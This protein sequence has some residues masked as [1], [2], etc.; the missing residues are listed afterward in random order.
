M[1]LLGFRGKAVLRVLPLALFLT[2]VTWAA[3][4]SS[5]PSDPIDLVRKTVQNELDANNSPAKYM[6]LDRKETPHGSQ[7][8]LIVE[9]REGT[10]GMVVENDGHPLTEEQRRAECERIERFLHDPAELQKKQAR[11]KEDSEHVTRIMK[12]LPDAFVYEYA[13]TETGEQDLGRPGDPLVRLNFRPRPDYTPPSRVEQV[14]TGMRGYL[15]IDPRQ[16]RI[17]KIDGTLEKEVG[18]GWGILGHLDRGGHF[19]V[20]QR[21]VG[22]NNWEV[23]RM[24]LAMTGKILFF[25]SLNIKS[26]ETYSKFQPVPADLTFHQGVDLLKKHEAEIAQNGL[27]NGNNR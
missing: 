6:F 2:P 18:F 13:G 11:E 25:K 9:T 5:L 16:S 15:L 23:T 8:T 22:N 21:D 17:A 19:L 7:T 3:Q 24:D 10:A 4:S 14:L 20:E 26:D 1:G 27:P 12:A